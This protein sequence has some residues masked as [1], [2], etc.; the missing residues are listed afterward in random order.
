[1]PLQRSRFT[2][3]GVG[4]GRK[5]NKY[6]NRQGGKS[7]ANLFQTKNARSKKKLIASSIKRIKYIS[8][9]RSRSEREREG[10][11]EGKF[12]LDKNPQ[13][14]RA[15]KKKGNKRQLSLEAHLDAILVFFFSLFYF[16]FF[17]E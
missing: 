16:Y 1:M 17:L 6:T 14:G 10:G 4:V 11:E 13:K 3:G 5:Q 8:E 9:I 15:R 12:V 2:L 7:A